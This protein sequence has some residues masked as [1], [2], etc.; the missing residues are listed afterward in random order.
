MGSGNSKLTPEGETMPARVR[1]VLHRWFEEIRRRRNANMSKKGLLKDA[2]EGEESSG[3]PRYLRDTERESTSPLHETTA[4]SKAAMPTVE[5]K[6]DAA[7]VPRPSVSDKTN[8]GS[9]EHKHGPKICG[10]R[11]VK[12]G[13]EEKQENKVVE[14]A[15]VVEEVVAVHEEDHH[16]QETT[17]EEEE[18]EEEDDEPGTYICPGSPSFRVYCVHST[19]DEEEEE[20]KKGSRHKNSPSTGDSVESNFSEDQEMTRTKKIKGNK[21]RRLKRA[22]RKSGPAVKNLLHVATCYHPACSGQDRA[23]LLEEKAQAG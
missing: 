3:R 5:E 15:V 13:G 7:V 19:D 2:V 1:P 11:D 6:S 8:K 18:E 20:S 22:I 9:K 14:K 17:E 16:D 23:H 12:G 10:K 4:S 21:G